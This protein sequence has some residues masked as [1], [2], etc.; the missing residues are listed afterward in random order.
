MSTTPSIPP[1]RGTVTVAVPVEQA[2]R[3]FTDQIHTWWPADY[4]I[5][6][7]GMA[8]AVLEPREG[9]RWYE[10]GIDG[11]QCDWG[12]VL[13][14][15]PPNRLVVTWQINGQWQFDPDPA[16][17]S[18]VEVRFTPDGPEQTTVELEHRHLERLVDGQAVRDTI[19]IQGGGWTTMLELFA[20]R[21]T[22]QA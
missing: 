2:F 5:G 15:E 1:L 3:V 8:R 6:Q 4:H 13:A 12:R 21:A 16:H 18:E 9:G 17:A 10:E 14:W 19:A 11:S 7:A 22:G 20:K